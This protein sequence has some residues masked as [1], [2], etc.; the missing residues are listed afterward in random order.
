MNCNIGHRRELLLLRGDKFAT[1]EDGILK[2]F[3]APATKSDYLQLT[4]E[5]DGRE[6]LGMLRIG[7]GVKGQSDRD[8]AGQKGRS[9]KQIGQLEIG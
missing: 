1:G 6:H 5:Y 7:S 4:I 3:R 2:S 8:L 9:I